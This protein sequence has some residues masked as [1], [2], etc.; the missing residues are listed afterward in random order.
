M[1]SRLPLL[2]VLLLGVSFT[3]T[4]YTCVPPLPAPPLA[5]IYRSPVFADGGVPDA[6]WDARRRDYLGFATQILAPTSLMNVI[7]HLERAKIDPA[8]TVPNDAVDVNSWDAVLLDIENLEDTADFDVVRLLWLWNGFPN[9]PMIQP[10]AWA[11]I[12]A[13]LLGFKYW[14]TDPTPAGKV[15]DMWAWSENHRILFH[16][17]EYI[18]GQT[19]PNEVFGVTGLT[20]AQHRDRARP[21]VLR[22]LD[23]RARW[24]F[25]EWHSHVYY[26]ESLMGL[27]LLAEWADEPEIRERA[28]MIV[29]VLLFDV[30]RHTFRNVFAGTHGR[31]YK[32][33]KMTARD[34]DTF[35]MTKMLFDTAESDYTSRSATTAI[36]LAASTRYRMPEVVRR[37][38][39]EVGPTVDR[40]RMSFAFDDREPIVPGVP[41][42]HPTGISYTDPAELELWWSM[43]AVTPWQILPLTFQTINANDLWDTSNFQDY[44]ALR[45]F[46]DP[47]ALPIIQGLAQ[48]LAPASSVALLSEINSYTYRTPDYMMG[49]AQDHR[50]GA[51]RDQ[52]HA[53]TVAF[54]ADA[55]VFTTHPASPPRVTLDWTDDGTPGFWSGTASLPRIAQHENV[56]IHVYSPGYVFTSSFGLGVFTRNEPYTHAYFPQER[57]DEV[58]QQGPWTFAR[59]REGYLALFSYRPASFLPMPAGVATNGLL[60][61]FELRATGGADNVWIVECGRQADWG[62]FDAFRTAVAAAAVTVTPTNVGITEPA[63]GPAYDVVYE[64]PSQGRVEF[65]WTQPLVVDGQTVPI[66]GYDRYDNPW[67]KTAYGSLEAAIWDPASATGLYLDHAQGIRI[68]VSVRDDLR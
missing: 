25:F 57:F 21:L 20:G 47:S 26:E 50:K 60:Q 17:A 24:G 63:V 58:V 66:T 34:H 37:V 59:R 13:D 51:R 5:E 8:F 7:A 52:G 43:G 65:G 11:R 4:G 61:P 48:Y 2:L 18:A 6:I 41:P 28:A 45:A 53:W 19:F 67:A 44:A 42:V 12:R 68:P 15:D 56:A 27:M 49:S 46:S 33:D 3:T 55:L 35:S 36:W 30:A 10:A 29:D 38:G 1:R 62:S 39:R 64:S 40:E 9:H 32:K 31:T 54:D 22:W 14:F 16:G 23:E